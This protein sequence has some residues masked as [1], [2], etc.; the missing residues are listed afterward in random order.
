MKLPFEQR[1]Q[2]IITKKETKTNPEYGKEPSKRTIQEL[3]S[4]G[5]II[6]NKPSG[7]TSHQAVD[8][9]K[10]ILN[11]K[12]AGH[13]GTLD[14]GVTGVL[15]IALSTA[16]RITNCL[17]TAGKEYVCLMHLHKPIKEEEIKKIFD[18]HF[19]GEIEQLPPVKSA[20]K[21]RMRKRTI[22]YIDIIEIK[23]QDVL[24]KVGC[25]AGTYIR[26]LIHDYGEKAGVGAHMAEL[27][28]TKAGPFQEKEMNTLQDIADAYHYYREGNSEPLKNIIKPVEQG[29]Q[30]LKKIYVHDGA[31]DTLCHG[32][33]L[34]V[35]GISKLDSDIKKGDTVAIMTLKNELILIGEAL[36]NTNN[37]VKLAKSIAVKTEQVFM[38]PGT[39]PKQTQPYSNH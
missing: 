10:K 15:P 7:P 1:Q 19:T 34:K 9:L 26:K 27:I 28:R 25:E 24:F 17:L 23:G 3:L 6:L 32:A 36:L 20:V 21:R 33:F 37:L 38:K 18:E 8:Y 35:P 14:P 4:T 5:I 13:S 2:E 16:T 30:H 12:K 11:I 29:T 22:Y 39:Y 31:V